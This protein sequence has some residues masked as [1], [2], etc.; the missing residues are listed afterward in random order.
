MRHS[1]IFIL[2]VW[3]LFRMFPTGKELVKT[4][5]LDYNE[6]QLELLDE[7]EFMMKV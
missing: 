7:K 6:L 5:E 4:N 1:Q 3:L 2:L